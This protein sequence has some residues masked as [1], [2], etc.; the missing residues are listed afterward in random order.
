MRHREVKAATAVADKNDMEATLVPRVR[1][2]KLKGC[3]ISREGL[4]DWLLVSFIGNG[5]MG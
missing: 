4:V 1:D 2:T 5:S 3:G